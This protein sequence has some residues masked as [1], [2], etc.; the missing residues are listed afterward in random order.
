V[1]SREHLGQQA[2]AAHLAGEDTFTYGLLYQHEA[3]LAESCRQ[4]LD[5][6]LRKL[7]KSVRKTRD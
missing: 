6:A 2:N 1:V 7:A 5:D 4:Q 3:D